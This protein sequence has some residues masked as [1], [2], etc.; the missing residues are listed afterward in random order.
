MVGDGTLIEAVNQVTME[1]APVNA[2]VKEALVQTDET[3]QWT[4]WER[5]WL[6]DSTGF[7]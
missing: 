5:G 1:I 2:Q 3:V 4:R 6:G 7:M